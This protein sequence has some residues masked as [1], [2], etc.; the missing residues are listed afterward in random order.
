MTKAIA[1]AMFLVAAI[2]IVLA[3]ISVSTMATMLD[4]GLVKPGA[5]LE[6]IVLILCGVVI[7]SGLGALLLKK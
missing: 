5:K 3:F 1:F 2:S 7:P 6:I 4:A